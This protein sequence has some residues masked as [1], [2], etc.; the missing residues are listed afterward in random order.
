DGQVVGTWSRTERATA[1]EIDLD[2][3][4]PLDAPT[5]ELV[6]REFER[7]AAFVGKPVAVR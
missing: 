6:E 5:R 2:V 4:S 3:S 1:I 7:Y